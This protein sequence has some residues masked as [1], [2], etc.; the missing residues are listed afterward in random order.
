MPSII[1]GLPHFHSIH[2]QRIH[3]HLPDSVRQRL[4]VDYLELISQT[5]DM[6]TEIDGWTNIILKVRIVLAPADNLLTMM[7]RQVVQIETLLVVGSQDDTFSR[8]ALTGK[9]AEALAEIVLCIEIVPN[10]TFVSD[11]SCMRS[12]EYT[13]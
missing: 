5:Q 13:P 4:R 3:S 11:T 12:K 10:L 6:T 9:H 7:Q 8:S 1:S 2:L